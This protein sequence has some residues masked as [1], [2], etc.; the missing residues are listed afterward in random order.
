MSDCA[1]SQIGVWSENS[2][3]RTV[4]VAV[5]GQP[6]LPADT[7]TGAGENIPIDLSPDYDA[8]DEIEF[9]INWLPWILRG[10]SAARLSAAIGDCT[11]INTDW[12]R[13]YLSALLRS[14]PCSRPEASR[15]D[16]R[17]HSRPIEEGF[18]PDFS[19]RN[20]ATVGHGS[21]SIRPPIDCIPESGNSAGPQNSRQSQP[22]HGAATPNTGSFASHRQATPQFDHVPVAEISRTNMPQLVDVPTVGPFSTRRFLRSVLEMARED[23]RIHHTRP[24]RI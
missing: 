20:R 3:N 17:A 5:Y 7:R 24:G 14:P 15:H 11:S 9:G 1:N 12:A 19:T 2:L 4:V 22:K 6:Q 16:R 21:W 13:I 23:G 10:V 8:S 18:T